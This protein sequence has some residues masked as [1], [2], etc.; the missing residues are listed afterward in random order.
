M[1]TL[2]A[3]EYRNEIWRQ[4]D[5]GILVCPVSRQKLIRRGTESLQTEHGEHSYTVLR[6]LPMLIADED[7]VK[8]YA[9]SSVQMNDEYTV[10]YLVKQESWFYRLRAHDYRSEASIQARDAIFANAGK[11]SVCVSIGGGPTRAH[12]RLLNLN[13]GPFPNV[14]IVADAHQLPYADNSVDAIH[15]EAVF[16]H[17]HT[18]TAAAAEIFR[19]L[20]SRGKAYVCTPFLQTYHG[21]P[22]HY[23]NFTL[24]GHVALFE[25][26]GLKILES[27]TCVGPTFVLRNMV[28]VFVANYT[29]FPINFLL[30]AIWAVISLVIAPFDILLR[31]RHDSH[32]MASTTYLLAEKP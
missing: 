9:K 5:L 15:C 27:G 22:S 1:K 11:A 28:S 4:I 13:I 25:R 16:E 31:K 10:E 32:I 19:V 24:T 12:P 23:Q 26:A 14:D 21:Y 29:P 17:L 6:G 7:V 3:E 8:K 30:R 20:K 2:D 18:P